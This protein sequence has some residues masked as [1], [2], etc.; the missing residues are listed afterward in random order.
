M[1]KSTSLLFA[2][3]AL[4]VAVVLASQHPRAA[5]QQPT[6]KL[7]SPAKV[8]Y[9]AQGE[10]RSRNFVVTGTTVRTAI[11]LAERAEKC[12]TELAKQWLGKELPDWPTPCRLE[13]CLNQSRLSGLSTFD[14]N[15]P[16]AAWAPVRVCL[17]GDLDGIM[18]NCLPHEITHTILADHFRRPV[19][20]WADEG[21]SILDESEQV[22]Q[23][24]DRMTRE[25]GVRWQLYRLDHLFAMRDYPPRVDV[26]YA[27]GFSVARFLVNRKDRPTF[28]AF[29]RGGMDGDWAA[30]AKRDYGFDSIE[31]MQE[32]WLDTLRESTVKK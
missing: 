27:Q 1:T 6:T 32:T 7:L 11:R 17:A 22:R 26:L 24:F 2:R 29:L 9:D 4:C 18:A 20:R 12:R 19:P 31:Q 10:F 23:R 8:D 25:F 15:A 28:L 3:A 30:A 13:V 14:F 5:G 16:A 21:T